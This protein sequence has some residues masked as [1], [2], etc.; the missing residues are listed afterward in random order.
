[1]KFVFTFSFLFFT[2]SVF[3][4]TIQVLTSGAK[5]SLRGLSVVN[6]S[7]LWASGSNGAVARSTNGGKTF[8]W[9][10][11]KGY[12]QRDFRDVEAFNSSTAIIMAVAEPAVILKTGDGGKSWQ[13]VFEDSTKGMFLD[14]MDFSGDY[15]V[16]VGSW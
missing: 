12:E 16:V 15:G 4:Q 9:L 5:T 14:A 3:P 8:E 6:D 7:V 10:V 11:V 13:K 2:F 1:M